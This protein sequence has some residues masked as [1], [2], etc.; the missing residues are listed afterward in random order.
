MTGL[1]GSECVAFQDSNIER[2]RNLK[3]MRIYEGN[4][5]SLKAASR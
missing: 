2:L 3:E 1:R 4:R 5:D